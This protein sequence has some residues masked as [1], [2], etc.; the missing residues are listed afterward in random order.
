[1]SLAER[2]KPPS[3]TDS[4]LSNRG[5]LS[6][7]FDGRYKFARFYAPNDFNTPKTL[8]QLFKHNDVQV[9]D[10]KSDPDEMRNLALER[11]KNGDTIM[12]L[13]GLLN[14]LMAREVGVNDG[15]FLPEAVRP[16]APPRFSD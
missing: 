14:E 5:F 13:N 7:I 6:F 15:S 16:K 3:L 9:F 2:R 8:E 12:R 10:L 1:M 4:K 11:E